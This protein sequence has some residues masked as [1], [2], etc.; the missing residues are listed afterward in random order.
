MKKQTAVDWLFN[1]LNISGGDDDIRI[2]QQALKIEREQI[3]DAYSQGMMDEIDCR[4]YDIDI[5]SPEY[6]YNETYLTDDTNNT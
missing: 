6:Y 2:L 4:L 3:E 5:P 1:N